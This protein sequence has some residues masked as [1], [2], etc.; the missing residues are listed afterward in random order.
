M[1]PKLDMVEVTKSESRTTSHHI[2]NFHSN[3]FRTYT[4]RL[5]QHCADKRDCDIM[6]EGQRVASFRIPD[7]FDKVPDSVEDTREWGRLVL[8]FRRTGF[9]P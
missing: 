5:L 7:G 4:P 3:M 1:P 6:V 2:V 9:T 8:K